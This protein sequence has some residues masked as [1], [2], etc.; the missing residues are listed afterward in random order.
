MADVFIVV[1]TK[2]T[3]LTVC[4]EIK[5]VFAHLLDAD[6]CKRLVEA[7]TSTRATIQPWSVRTRPED[8]A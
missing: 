8:R 5:G 3:N 4:T 2:V 6:K 1:G 7:D